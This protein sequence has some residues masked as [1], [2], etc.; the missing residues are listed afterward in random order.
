MY[1]CTVTNRIRV[2]VKNNILMVSFVVDKKG[3]AE[4]KGRA[5]VERGKCGSGRLE[6]NESGVR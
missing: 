3:T 1:M 2:C 5:A 6:S 4:S